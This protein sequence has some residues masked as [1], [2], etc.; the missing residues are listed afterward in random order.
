MGGGLQIVKDEFVI[1]AETGNQPPAYPRFP[2]AGAMR[3]GARVGKAIIIG[4]VI[5]IV[6]ICLRL[7]RH[8]QRSYPDAQHNGRHDLGMFDVESDKLNAFDE[9]DREFLE[10]AGGLIAH[11]LH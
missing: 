6:R 10:R 5:R 1:L 2:S 4:D 8:G 3:C 9:E 7:I 11:C